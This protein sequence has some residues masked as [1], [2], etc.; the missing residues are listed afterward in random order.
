MFFKN[1]AHR[2]AHRAAVLAQRV[3]EQKRS[4][5]E[6]S[7]IYAQLD[8]IAPGS[9]GFAWRREM[10]WHPTGTVRR[11]VTSSATTRTA[12][13]RVASIPGRA[14]SES[15]FRGQRESCS[16]DSKGEN[17]TCGRIA[18]GYAQ[19]PDLPPHGFAVSLYLLLPNPH[20]CSDNSRSEILGN[21]VT[22]TGDPTENRSALQPMTASP[23]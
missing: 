16:I 1:V 23:A 20:I 2:V 8:T 3:S 6:G 17:R 15:V 11:L 10:K 13:Q 5:I 14:D 18:A 19:A 22:V 9:M 12:L 21:Q 7:G 4:S